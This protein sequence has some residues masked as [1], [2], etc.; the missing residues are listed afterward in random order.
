MIDVDWVVVPDDVAD[1]VA[2][3]EPVL[4]AVL[5]CDDVAVE[6]AVVVAVVVAELVPVL[7]ADVVPVE[8]P[9]VDGDVVSV[10]VAVVVRVVVP[11]VVVVGEV[12]GVLVME[13]VPLVVWVVVADVDGVDVA[14]DVAVVDGV[15]VPV[16]VWLV[17]VVG[18]EVCV[19]VG[20]VFT[21]VWKLP[22][23]YSKMASFSASAVSGQS[24]ASIGYCPSAQSTSSARPCGPVICVTTV[25]SAAA[26][27]S[28]SPP[29]PGT[30]STASPPS[31]MHSTAGAPSS[32]AWI[33]LFSTPTCLAQL[34][35][36]PNARKL[37]PYFA[38]HLP[39]VSK[40]VVVTVVVGLVV[41]V[42]LVVGLVVVVGD[43]VR[44][45]VWLVVEVDD[46]VV[47]AVEVGDVVP[48]VV[49]DVVWLVVGV[50]TWHALW[51]LFASKLM[52]ASAIT[53]NVAAAALQSV[54]STNSVC[55]AHLMSSPVP[56][57]PL[58]SRSAAFSAAA[59]WLQLSAVSDTT[60]AT[61]ST[62]RH[63]I[64]PPT[65]VGHASSTA[66]S[67]ATCVAQLW[68]AST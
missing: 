10:E 11:V 38:T 37:S 3:V 22:S 16:V 50:V 24:D 2:V 40:N 57:G 17:V 49:A 53:L 58:N 15:L 36:V 43:V 35:P 65:V 42:A 56:S 5:V 67:T 8:V 61:P 30:E 31:S 64:A 23:E 48:L 60:A 33:T 25:F 4:V 29:P 68:V 27:L 32:H 34:A 7:D 62:S 54:V 45:V 14:V 39:A 26:T 20:V 13:V 1:E 28:H 52:N 44:D 19:L 59:V 46:G 18:D 55:S 63:S 21:H 6:V 9:V 12:L 66:F 47:V 41:V 51:K